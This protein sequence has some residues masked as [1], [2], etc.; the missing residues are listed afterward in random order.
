MVY[1]I[2]VPILFLR[3]TA[4]LAVVKPNYCRIRDTHGANARYVRDPG[5]G[6]H[7][8]VRTYV[9]VHRIICFFHTDIL[10]AAVV[11]AVSA[12]SDM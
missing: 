7:R 12:S 5:A 10:R 4:T 9:R 6:V 11:F 1:C 3:K 2:L 8:G